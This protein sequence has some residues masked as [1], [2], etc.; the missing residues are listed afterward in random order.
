MNSPII[1]EN[2]PSPEN[3]IT[4]RRGKATCAPMACNIAFAIEP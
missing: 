1:M 4:C 3:E 2:P